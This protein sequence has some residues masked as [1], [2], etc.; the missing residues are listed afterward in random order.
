MYWYYDFSINIFI[1]LLHFH[2]DLLEIK[3]GD[4]YDI[5]RILETN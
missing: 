3:K 5:R 1:S 4:L 2:P